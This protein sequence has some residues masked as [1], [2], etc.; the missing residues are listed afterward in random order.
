MKAVSVGRSMGRDEECR[1]WIPG[2]GRMA[3]N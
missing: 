3:G 1:L 2:G